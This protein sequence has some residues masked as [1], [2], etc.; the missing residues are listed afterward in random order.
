MFFGSISSW[1]KEPSFVNNITPVEF[2]SSRPT[3]NNR[4]FFGTNSMTVFR[5][6]GSFCVVIYPFGLLRIITQIFF[7]I[8][9]RFPS[10]IISSSSLTLYAGSVCKTPLTVV[11]A[12]RISLS[13]SLREATPPIARNLFNRI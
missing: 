12:A 3:V 7:S 13:A 5:P 4:G 1:A 6:C 11:V 10:K 2:R 9:I 8:V